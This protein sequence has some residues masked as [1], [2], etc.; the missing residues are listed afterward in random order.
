MKFQ[1]SLIGIAL[2]LVFILA[3][4]SAQDPADAPN[5]PVFE[6]E[7]QALLVE[8]EANGAQVEQTGEIEQ[9]SFGVDARQVTVNGFP[10]QV[11]I[12]QNEEERLN[13]Q[14]Q[15]AQEP[16]MV[17]ET[18]LADGGQVLIW[19]EGNIMAIFAGTDS[20]VVDPMN[21]ALGEP[22]LILESGAVG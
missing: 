5:D 16:N 7:Y 17:P 19:A 11:I 20:G 13:V 15:L 12:F 9:P 18:G 6:T 10:I 4:C 22:V 2:L 3:A 1:K 8:L 21:E 14:E